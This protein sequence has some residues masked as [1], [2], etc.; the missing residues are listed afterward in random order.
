VRVDG[1]RIDF[2]T[3][4]PGLSAKEIEEMT[5]DII[6]NRKPIPE[7]IM[8]KA[9]EHAKMRLARGLPVFAMRSES[10]SK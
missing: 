1:K 10:P 3:L 5:K 4:V 2:P 7:P 8:R 9:I 6:P